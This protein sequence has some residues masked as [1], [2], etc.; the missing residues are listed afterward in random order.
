[1]AEQQ[2]SKKKILNYIVKFWL[3]VLGLFCLAILFFY[4][5][6]NSWFGPMPSFAELENP[7]S[8][9]ASE[10]ISSDGVLLGTFFI[11]N[12]SN[13]DYRDISPNMINALKAIEDIR[14]EDHSG[15]DQKALMRVFYGVVTGNKKG[16][17]STL[18][19]Q[20]AK[21]LF[22]RGDL[23]TPQLVLRKF[24]EWVTAIKLEKTYSK[25]EII[26]MYMNTV[27]YGQCVRQK[28]QPRF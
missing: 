11:E 28:S 7:Q 14:F 20:L 1:M 3:I 16:G 17:G 23:N 5:V 25:E 12:R 13:V 21:N 9:L 18:T 6:A 2:K 10:V 22:P 8:N 26:A 27:F 15:I 24:Q 4:G 19:Q